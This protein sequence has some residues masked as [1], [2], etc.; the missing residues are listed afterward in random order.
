MIL[1]HTTGVLDTYETHTTHIRDDRIPE[2]AS[3]YLTKTEK[4]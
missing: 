1:P 4:G 2:I 3:F